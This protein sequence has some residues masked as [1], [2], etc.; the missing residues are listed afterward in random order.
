MNQRPLI[1]GGA[2]DVLANDT[3]PAIRQICANAAAAPERLSFA[4]AI[5]ANLKNPD[6][7]LRIVRNRKPSAT[8]TNRARLSKITRSL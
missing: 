1:F 4:K 7:L 2:L 8:A 5:V 6:A 3:N